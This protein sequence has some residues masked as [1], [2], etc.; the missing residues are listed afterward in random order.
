MI[1]LQDKLPI[2][3]AV[4][5]NHETLINRYYTYRNIWTPELSEHLEVQCETQHVVNKYAVYLKNGFRVTIEY[6]K[7]GK[8]GRCKK[9]IFY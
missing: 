7:K 8:S 3:I 9:A 4:A 5:I 2:I 1:I 6:L